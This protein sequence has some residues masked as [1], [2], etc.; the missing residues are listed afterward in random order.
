MSDQ[1]PMIFEKVLGSLRPVNEAARDAVKAI[2]GK[3]VIKITRMTRNQRRRGF[4]WT[5]LGVVAELLTDRTGTPWDAE[6]LHDDLRERLGLGEWLVT[7]TGRRKFKP[8]STS[9]KSM[10]EA[11]R[12]RWT[13]RVVSYLSNAIGVEAHL[14]IDEVRQRGGDVEEA[15]ERHAA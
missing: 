14:L 1:P 5:L 13:D 2:D 12:A 3:C 9:D 4:Y 15:H 7:P 6:T 11:D 10:N 8:R